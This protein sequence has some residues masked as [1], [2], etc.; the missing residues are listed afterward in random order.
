MDDNGEK[1]GQ[2]TKLSPQGDKPKFVM[3]FSL[4]MKDD[5][6]K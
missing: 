2:D 4:R 1:V 6:I 3:V 5:T